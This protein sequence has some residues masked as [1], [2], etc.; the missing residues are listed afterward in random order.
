MHRTPTPPAYALLSTG[1]FGK[2]FEFGNS[3]GDEVAMRSVRAVDP[4]RG[5]QLRNHAHGDALASDG[6]VKKAVDVA[7]AAGIGNNLFGGSQSPHAREEICE[8]VC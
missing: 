4:I 8:I 1:Q 2:K 3:T 5:Q 6:E 7:L